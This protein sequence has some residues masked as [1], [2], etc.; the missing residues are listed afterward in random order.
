YTVTIVN[1]PVTI[2][3]FILDIA[4][5]IR[6]KHLRGAISDVVVILK[7]AHCNQSTRLS[8]TVSLFILVSIY[9]VLLI[10]FQNFVFAIGDIAPSCQVYLTH[11][12]LVFKA[13]F[14]TS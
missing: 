7:Q 10:H 2:Y 1:Y 4:R 11:F 3:V 8:H 14:E 12:L 13:S 6:A 5:L 9:I